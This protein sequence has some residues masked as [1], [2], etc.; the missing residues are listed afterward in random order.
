PCPRL[1][2]T[3]LLYLQ[4]MIQQMP[5]PCNSCNGVGEVVPEQDRCTDCRGQRTI[6]E[7]KRLE[8]VISPGMS[9]QQQLTF[10][11]EADQSPDHDPGDAVI[12]LQ[13]KEHPYFHRE[14]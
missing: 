7:N 6:K 1:Q 11:G 12:V 4:G 2:Y 5:I 9:H 10:K 8:V 14:G 3:R 13:Q